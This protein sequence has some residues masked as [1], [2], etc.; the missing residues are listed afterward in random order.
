MTTETQ[1]DWLSQWDAQQQPELKQGERR[2]D[3]P[4]LFV[5]LP[6]NGEAGRPPQQMEIK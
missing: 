3:P 4:N 6:P 2:S 5:L 1:A